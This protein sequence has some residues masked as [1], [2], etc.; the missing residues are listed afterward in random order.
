MILYMIEMQGE[1]Y[2]LSESGGG[3]GG[4]FLCHFLNSSFR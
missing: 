4:K 3:G 2:S 1:F